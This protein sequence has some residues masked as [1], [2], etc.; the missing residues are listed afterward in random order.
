MNSPKLILAS[1]SPRRQQFFHA[2]E[3]PFVAES[4]DIDESPTPNETPDEMVARLA[5][6]KALTVARRLAAKPTEDAKSILPADFLVV[7]A[8]TVVAIDG[9][10][11][12][13]PVDADDAKAM[14][15]T[16]RA[17]PHQVHTAL[18]IAHFVGGVFKRSCSLINTTTVNM[19]SYTD[20]EISAYVATG[21]PLDKAGA[22]AIQHQQFRPVESFLGCPAGVM[23]LPAADLMRLLSEFN[24]DV[25]RS[26]SQICRAL[27][28]FQCCQERAA[29]THCLSAVTN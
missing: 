18:A 19:R 22:Y 17:R 14:L 6:A 25:E 7:G 4:A 28:G 2:L 23:G 3:I 9:Q 13:K 24:L 27:T 20:A 8:D 16:L 11:L 1:E 29:Q 26:P 5:G 10:I 12:G 15:S 21:D